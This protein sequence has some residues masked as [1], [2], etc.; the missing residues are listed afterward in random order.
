MREV[1]HEAISRGI[2]DRE[3]IIAFAQRPSKPPKGSKKDPTF[4][5]GLVRGD[6]LAT[7]SAVNTPLTREMERDSAWWSNPKPDKYR[8]TAAGRRVPR[9]A[10]PPPAVDDANAPASKR[11]KL[12]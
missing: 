10:P 3:G 7:R 8:L 5:P 4:E 1:I 6:C 2:R 11:A 9:R 12:Y